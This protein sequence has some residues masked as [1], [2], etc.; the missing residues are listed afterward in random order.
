VKRA[1]SRLQR[2]Q[3]EHSRAIQDHVAIIREYNQAAKY[4]GI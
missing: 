3:L 2:K 1:F 4:R